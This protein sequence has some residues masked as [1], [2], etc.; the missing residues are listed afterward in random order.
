MHEGT[1]RNVSGL[2]GVPP[3]PNEFYIIPSHLIN[4]SKC[5]IKENINTCSCDISPEAFNQLIQNH[6][7]ATP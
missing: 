2:D 3:I 1:M 7:L 6:F 5:I 4:S